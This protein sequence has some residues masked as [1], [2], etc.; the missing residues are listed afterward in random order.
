VAGYRRA[1]SLNTFSRN[2]GAR[3]FAIVETGYRSNFEFFRL[4]E[5]LTEIRAYLAR[6]EKATGQRCWHG[7]ATPGIAEVPVAV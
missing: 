4:T 7:G 3:I 2:S 6:C 5:A 1:L